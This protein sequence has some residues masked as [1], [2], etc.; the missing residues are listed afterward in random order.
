MA[1]KFIARSVTHTGSYQAISG[2][3][4]VAAG[5][6]EALAGNSAASYLKGDDGSTDVCIDKGVSF[7]LTDVDLKT[8][9][10]KGTSG[11]KV[12]FIGHT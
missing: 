9:Q 10:V 8:I 6:L 12:I 5:V 4:I 2:T 3:T 7:L 11:D 1:R